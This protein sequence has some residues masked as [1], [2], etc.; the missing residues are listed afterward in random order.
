M[1]EAKTHVLR[2]RVYYEDTAAAGIVYYANYFKFAERGRTEM[3]RSAGVEHSLILKK[4]GLRFLVRNCS[5]EYLSSA[6]LDDV[7]EVHTK[8]LGIRAAS[9]I[10][11]QI[12]GR[13]GNT[14]ASI[15]SRIACVD[16]HGSPK[17]LP[18]ELET[19]LRPYLTYGQEAR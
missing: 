5:I 9:M 7:I 15:K 3:L 12:I 16:T 8:I 4:T 6:R 13:L 1:G 18:P 10:V 17:R 11:M 19:S 2:L 14:L